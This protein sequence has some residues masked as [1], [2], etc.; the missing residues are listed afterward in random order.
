MKHLLDTPIFTE[1]MNIDNSIDRS[2]GQTEF[3]EFPKRD[4]AQVTKSM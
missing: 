2:P 3:R 4:R 1:F